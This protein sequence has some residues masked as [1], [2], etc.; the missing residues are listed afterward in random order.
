MAV[1]ERRL[2][3]TT[4]A[5]ALQMFSMVWSSATRRR[6]LRLEGQ[7]VVDRARFVQFAPEF[8]RLGKRSC[9]FDQIGIE[10]AFRAR[11]R[12][13]DRGFGIAMGVEHIQRLRQVHDA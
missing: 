6:S 5:N 12:H 9:R 13:L 3:I 8:A 4:L 11:L 1:R 7:G 2:R 10:P